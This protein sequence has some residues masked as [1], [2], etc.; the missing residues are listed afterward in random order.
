MDIAVLVLA[1]Y[2]YAVAAG[3]LDFAYRYIRAELVQL[4]VLNFK[5]YVA[6]VYYYL[7]GG[8]ERRARVYKTG[9]ALELDAVCRRYCVDGEFYF[10]V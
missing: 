8:S 7:S 6:A 3:V 1:R 9:Y 10:A 4:L 5:R 2:R